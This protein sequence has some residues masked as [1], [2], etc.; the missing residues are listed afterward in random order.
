MAG[1]ISGVGRLGGGSLLAQA[2]SLAVMPLITRLY[3]TDAFGIFALYAALTTI[4]FPIAN[5]RLNA[6][7]LLPYSERQATGLFLAACVSTFFFALVLAPLVVLAVTPQLSKSPS[8]EIWILWLVPVG[9]LVQGQLQ[10]LQFWILRR[11]GFSTMALGTIAEAIGDRATAVGIGYAEAGPTGLVLGRILGP[12]AHFAI[13]ARQSLFTRPRPHLRRTRLLLVRRV[14]RR[15]RRFPL[16]S[17]PAFLFANG[18]REVP[19]LL[20]AL[21]QPAGAVGA[22]ALGVRVLNWPMLL[23]GDAI[24][25]V[26]LQKMASEKRSPESHGVVAEEV[27]RYSSY[28]MVPPTLVLVAFGDTLFRLVFGDSWEEAGV[29]SRI[30]A[31]S[32]FSAFL[33]RILS[34]FFDVL[35]KQPQRLALDVA[36]FVSRCAG[37]FLGNMLWGVYGALIGLA[38][39]TLAVHGAGLLYLFNIFGIGFGK[40]IRL[41]ISII[42]MLFPMI[43]SI[44]GGYWLAASI[45]EVTIWLAAGT[46]TQIALWYRV[47]K[48]IR[49]AVRTLAMGGA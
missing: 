33:Y 24:S 7:M 29:F 34:V 45:Y 11:Q 9:V 48:K 19:T 28:L 49:T 47:D 37:L 31:A 13:L 41:S 30:L 26:F 6:A 23:I 21:L 3:N 36:L 32:F 25:K 5:L 44:A 15:Y 20:L 42:A 38:A 16:Y 27:L 17:T 40:V 8:T 39:A 43:L 1:F 10:N 46:I 4:L 14:V 18:A 12:V 2:I 22:Y 35:E